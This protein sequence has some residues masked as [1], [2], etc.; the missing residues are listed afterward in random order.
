MYEL[1]GYL[2]LA[3]GRPTLLIPVFIREGMNTPYVQSMDEFYRIE[4]FCPYYD[5]EEFDFVSED[6]SLRAS[7][8]QGG[9]V[10]F[11]APDGTIFFGGIDEVFEIVECRPDIMTHAPFL[12]M[13]L[14][15]IAVASLAEQYANW[16]EVANALFEDANQRKLWLD[17]ELSLYQ[18]NDKIW[19][20]IEAK[21]KPVPSKRLS[22]ESGFDD[23]DI[24]M[25]LS[26]P[27]YY[28]F[29]GWEALWLQLKSRLPRDER[30]YLIANDWLY[31]LFSSMVEIGRPRRVFV[32][33]LAYWKLV[34][35]P[36]HRFA[37]FLSELI[38]DGSFFSDDLRMPFSSL[39][40]ALQIIGRARISDRYIAALLQTLAANY[41]SY[42]Q[43]DWLLSQLEELTTGPEDIVEIAANYRGLLKSVQDRLSIFEGEDFVEDFKMRWG[44][45]IASAQRSEA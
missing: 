34:S 44:Q 36:D 23:E 4:E 8:G 6:R 10:A 32:E 15:R 13:Q 40:A 30:V 22:I 38:G 42:S 19:K 9:I 27:Q 12:K 39:V 24:I 14:D 5:C 11:R 21:D 16:Q 1:Q 35:E 31:A 26:D 33:V 28:E 17:G 37:E 7:V 2:D 43:T 18:N 3:P 41:F 29:S 20:R 45:V 25:L